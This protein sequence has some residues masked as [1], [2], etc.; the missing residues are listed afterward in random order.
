MG[1]AA[2][3][4]RTARRRAQ[5]RRS[6]GRGSAAQKASWHSTRRAKDGCFASKNTQQVARR[7]RRR[8]PC[9]AREG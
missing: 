3:K 9:Q 2:G 6:S 5:G 4:P 8:Q 1:G 7:Q